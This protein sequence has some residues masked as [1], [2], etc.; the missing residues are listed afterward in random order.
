MQSEQMSDTL[1]F[2][3]L[4][5]SSFN[6]LF[7]WSMCIFLRKTQLESKKNRKNKSIFSLNKEPFVH[8]VKYKSNWILDSE[9]AQLSSF[10]KE[11][12]LDTK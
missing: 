4:V 6:R 9:S 5:N 10:W 2:S 8:K 7:L 11:V 3:D 1:G 12:G